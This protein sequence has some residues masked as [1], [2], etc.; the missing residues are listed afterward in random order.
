MKRLNLLSVL[1]VMFGLAL[2]ATANDSQSKES[3]YVGAEAPKIAAEIFGQGVRETSWQTP[4]AEQAGFHLPPG[5]SINLFASEGMSEGNIAKPLN[6]AWDHRGRLWIT[7]SVEYPYPADPTSEARD[8]IK[9]L[10]DTDAD[11]HADRCTTFA[12]QLN[13]PMGLLPVADGVICFSIPYVWHLRDRNGDDIADERVKLLGPFDTTRDTHGMVNAMR[14][15]L[16]G[17][18]YACH[19]FNN[20]SKVTASDGSE[21]DLNSGNTFRFREDGSRIEL[22]TRGQVNPFGLTQDEFGNWFSADCHSKPLTALLPGACY[23]SFSRPHDG[24]GF[25]PPMMEHLHG[26]TAISGL[27]LYRA[28]QFPPAYRNLLYSGNVMTSRI[29]CNRLDWTGSTATA[30]EYDDFLTSEDPWF[31]PVDIQIGPDGA[32]Y[33]AD[34]YN[35]IIGHYE[36]PLEHPGRDRTSGRIWRITY[37]GGEGQSP[38]PPNRSHTKSNHADDLL[39]QGQAPHGNAETNLSLAEFVASQPV[40]SPDL[41][42]ALV[43]HLARNSEPRWI[44]QAKQVWLE[45]SA[46]TKAN[47]SLQKDSAAIT[48]PPLHRITLRFLLRCR[49]IS[50]DF[51]LALTETVQRENT[52]AS[53]EKS[54]L[55]LRVCRDVGESS[56]QHFIR[57]ARAVLATDFNR[58]QADSLQ[59]END[60]RSHANSPRLPPAP[61]LAGLA[62]RSASDYLAEFGDASD[63]RRLML[64]FQNSQQS[65]KALRHSL[66]IAMRN[67]LRT[68]NVLPT[69]LSEYSGNLPPCIAGVLP[70]IDSQ[71]AAFA[72]LAHVTKNHENGY[73]ESSDASLLKAA[74]EM[75]LKHLP[76]SGDRLSEAIDSIQLLASSPSDA[77]SATSGSNTAAASV[78]EA[79]LLAKMIQRHQSLH[80]SHFKSNDQSASGN[81]LLR[82]EGGEMLARLLEQ[83]IEISR[84]EVA[85]AWFDNQG[86]TWDAQPRSSADGIDAQLLSSHTRGESYTGTLATDSFEC[87]A[88]IEFWVAGHNGFPNEDDLQA[89]FVRLVESASGKTLRTAYPP[90]NDTAQQVVWDTQELSGIRVRLEIVDGC[91]LNAYAWL[92]AGRFGNPILNPASLNSNIFPAMSPLL[93]AGCGERIQEQLQDLLESLPR[94]SKHRGDL[95]AAIYRGNNNPLAASLCEHSVRHGLSD[96][97]PNRQVLSAAELFDLAKQLCQQATTPV[98][99]DLATQ[100]SRSS[101]G[102][103]L[104]ADLIASGHLGSDA[105]ANLTEDQLPSD[106]DSERMERLKQAIQ[107]AR[108]LPD[109]DINKIE[110]QIAKFGSEGEDGEKIYL[111]H[112]ANCHQLRGKGKLVGPQLDGVINRP[113]SRLLQDILLPNANVDTAFLQSTILLDTD[114]VLAGLVQEIDDD[115]LLLTNTNG[116]Q[117]EIE[118]SQVVSLKQS[119]SSLMPGNFNEI[120]KPSQLAALFDFI[121][122][123]R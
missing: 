17:W 87:P 103:A 77:H 75:V 91:S 118:R 23:P 104:A 67:Q 22:V 53:L 121:R 28:G 49:E 32:L 94:G 71:V 44:Q 79:E 99:R 38:T 119:T 35:K 8:S 14:R 29:N 26:S 95:L 63:V 58:F 108:N 36:V 120:L 117:R 68:P 90:R 34:F 64:A 25:A 84:D 16:D 66:R 98:Q 50:P 5:F 65:D 12:D 13:I 101:Q 45:E 30:E 109:F 15:G 62:K 88:K 41:E 59:E 46:S 123:A 20:Q 52:T 7:N 31:R 51:A 48:T 57:F 73:S 54:I 21:V 110:T 82:R 27:A 19:G 115:T 69:M 42:S 111:S 18:I 47:A 33:V 60:S 56:R 100:L 3:V 76:A 24:L 97:V 102:I 80:R 85:V 55:I 40:T 9:I 78:R 106:L 89:N 83:A 112:C 11:G 39:S 72:L 81:Q 74:R 114:E 4:Q 113:S 107:N 93:A 61:T 37:A 2:T 1:A 6:M 86:Q 116:E 70:G 105:F 10:E 122:S 43:E 96:Q 92:A